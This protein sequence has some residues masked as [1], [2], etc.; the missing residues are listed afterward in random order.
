MSE[1]LRLFFAVP[2]SEEIKQQA[3]QIQE[4]CDCPDLKIGWVGPDRMHFTLIFLGDTPQARV[5]QLAEVARRAAQLHPPHQVTVAGAGAFPN[6]RRPR[7]IWVGCTTGAQQLTAL[8]TELDHALT[9]AKLAKPEKRGFTPHLTLGRVRKGHNFNEL[10]SSLKELSD[11][12]LGQMPVDHFVLMHCDLQP[13]RPE[14]YT[15]LNRFEIGK[16]EEDRGTSPQE[17]QFSE[18]VR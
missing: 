3:Q 9:E 8:G 2:T 7:I 5:S 4:Q 12:V 14:I 17:N 13:G 6:F 10:T 1:D 11:C 18:G 15:E 16:S